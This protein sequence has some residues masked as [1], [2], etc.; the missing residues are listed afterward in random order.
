MPNFMK[1]VNPEIQET[2]NTKHKKHCRRAPKY[3]IIKLLKTNDKD[4]NLKSS[5]RKK[6][7]ILHRGTTTRMTEDISSET[8]Q[9]SK[10]KTF[11]RQTKA[12]RIHYQQPIL[13][14]MLKEVLNEAEGKWYQEIWIHTKEWW[15]LEI[16][17]FYSIQLSW[18]ENWLVKQK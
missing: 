15:A 14:G 7:H 6:C 4:K 16:H 17:T 18:Q 5:Q 3:I 9:V 1:T 12:E 11:S 13:Q 10:I 8:M 2:T